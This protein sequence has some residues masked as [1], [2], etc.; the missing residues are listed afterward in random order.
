[1]APHWTPREIE[2]LS[3]RVGLDSYAKLSRRLGRS[4]EAIKLYRCRNGLPRFC[5]TFY[6]YSLLAKELGRNRS[7]LRRYHDLGWLV[8]RKATWSS[9]YGQKP[10]IFTEDD[11]VRFLRKHHSLFDWKRV[12]NRFFRN[13]IRSCSKGC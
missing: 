9:R 6:S 4:E 10:M 1:M 8:G 2:L 3:D 11:V 5:D 7:S 13:I 12:P